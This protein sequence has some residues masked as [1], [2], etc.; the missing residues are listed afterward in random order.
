MQKTRRAG[1]HLI[2]PHAADKPQ[3]AAPGDIV[4]C[5]GNQLGI[6]PPGSGFRPYRPVCL[7]AEK[8]RKAPLPVETRAREWYNAGD[9]PAEVP[10]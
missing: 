9:N 6:H 8:R 7:M 2:F 10:T 5:R 4:P 3:R 1:S